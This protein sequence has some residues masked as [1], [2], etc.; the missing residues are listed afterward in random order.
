M[1]YLF[2]LV[3]IYILV[4]TVFNIISGNGGRAGEIIV[5]GI[6]MLFILWV[7]FIFIFNILLDKNKKMMAKINKKSKRIMILKIKP[8]QQHVIP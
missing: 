5:S 3:I 6:G 7:I 1:K 8:L 4:G 2:G